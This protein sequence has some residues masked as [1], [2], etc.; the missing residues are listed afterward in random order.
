MVEADHRDHAICHDSAGAARDGYALAPKCAIP[1]TIQARASWAV[2]AP[3]E[4]IVSRQGTPTNFDAN[5]S[6][7]VFGFAA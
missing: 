3:V 6:L 4:P 2:V 7:V 1:A 5:R